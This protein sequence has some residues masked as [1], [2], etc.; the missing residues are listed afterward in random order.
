MLIPLI[1]FINASR[2]GG[3]DQQA[4]LRMLQDP[5][6][7]WANFTLRVTSRKTT[8]RALTARLVAPSHKRLQARSR[9][10]EEYRF[11]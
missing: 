4:V 2:A 7:F 6:K 11:E 8:R 9:A 5:A 3:L 10:V 1:D